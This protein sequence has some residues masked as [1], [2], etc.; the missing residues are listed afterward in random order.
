MSAQYGELR[1]TSIGDWFVI[2]RHPCKFQRVSRLG[3]VIARHCSSGRQ[4]NFAALNRVRHLYA[5]GQ[6]S[7]WAFAHISSLDTAQDW[8]KIAIQ[9]YIQTIK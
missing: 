3:S 2:L 5:A 7:H 8:D 1:L 4:P 6:P 9:D